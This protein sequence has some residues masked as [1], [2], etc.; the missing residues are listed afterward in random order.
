MRIISVFL[1][2]I[3]LGVQPSLA[4][5]VLITGHVKVDQS[6]KKIIIK[7]GPIPKLGMNEAMIMVFD[8]PDPNM[9]KAVKPG[10]KVNFDAERVNG[11]LTLT[12]IEKAK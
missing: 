1:L 3:F 4:E 2:A 12:K 7:H 10:D 6:A 11:Q 9:S 5:S 8:A